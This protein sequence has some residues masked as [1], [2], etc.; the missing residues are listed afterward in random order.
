MARIFTGWIVTAVF[1]LVVATCLY[2]AVRT[3]AFQIDR[4]SEQAQEIALINAGR[5]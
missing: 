4:F 2:G 1:A 3:V 5:G